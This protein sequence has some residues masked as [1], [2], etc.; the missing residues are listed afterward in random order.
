M[1]RTLQGRRRARQCWRTNW[2]TSPRT[3]TERAEP[4]SRDWKS[5]GVAGGSASGGGRA[6]AGYEGSRR[7]RSAA[8]F[9]ERRRMGWPCIG[10][11]ALALGALGAFG[12][13]ALFG[14]TASAG[15]VLGTVA[16]AAAVGGFVGW[17]IG[18]ST[19]RSSKVTP[20]EADLLIRDAT[21][22]TS[23]SDRGES[24][25]FE[26]EGQL[27]HQDRIVYRVRCQISR[28]TGRM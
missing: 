6:G 11:G 12:L 4:R 14:A 10:A 2:R 23:E 5:G 19:R 24:Q 7:Q 15:A 22:R 16:G 8:H 26:R 9:E 20:D 28:Q 27:R 3:R 18:R 13:A 17:L 21:A 25:R 1:A